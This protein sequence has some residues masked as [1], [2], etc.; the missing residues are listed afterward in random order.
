EVTVSNGKSRHWRAITNTDIAGCNDVT[1]LRN[2]DSSRAKAA[3]DIKTRS[4]LSETED[5]KVCSCA[6]FRYQ[7]EI[8]CVSSAGSVV[9]EVVPIRISCVSSKANGGV[10]V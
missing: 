3:V 8:V 6:V 7:T 1:V 9:C 10:E 4:F 2:R 5:I